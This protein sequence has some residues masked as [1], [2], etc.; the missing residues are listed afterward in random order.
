MAA[1]AIAR[2]Q[3]IFSS[4]TAKKFSFR[5]GSWSSVEFSWAIDSL[6]FMIK[7]RYF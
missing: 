6:I 4:M 2:D 5:M 3:V 1:K 7:V